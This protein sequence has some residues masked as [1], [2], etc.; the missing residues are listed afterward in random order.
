MPCQEAKALAKA[1]AEQFD[2]KHQV[3]A[4]AAEKTAGIRDRAREFDEKHQVTEK[5]GGA[6]AKGKAKTAGLVD[7]VDRVTAERDAHKLFHQLD[8][9]GNARVVFEQFRIWLTSDGGAGEPEPEGEPQAEGGAE[10]IAEGVPPRVAAE[11]VAKVQELWA[12][13]D[14]TGDGGLEV[15]AFTPLFL[16]LQD[17]GLIHVD[18]SRFMNSARTSMSGFASV[19]SERTVS[20]AGEARVLAGTAAEGARATVRATVSKHSGRGG[21]PQMVAYY[22]ARAEGDGERTEPA[23]VSFYQQPEQERLMQGL[24][25]ARVSVSGLA[26]VASEKTMKAKGKAE[27]ALSP[28]YSAHL[29]APDLACL[30]MLA[31]IWPGEH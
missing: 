28:L 14:Y 12:K 18:R 13:E 30:H 31:C 23:I 20:L 2:E 9:D 7:R 3:K 27:G 1:K 11:D 21:E 29:A 4:R 25:A 26:S 15:D 8:G 17:S 22:S 6:V 10:P 19:A 16:S 5:A 24:Q